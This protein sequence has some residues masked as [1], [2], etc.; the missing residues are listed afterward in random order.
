MISITYPYSNQLNQFSFCV[1]GSI[2]LEFR[3][4]DRE[5]VINFPFCAT[6]DAIVNKFHFY[7]NNVPYSI[8]F[9]IYVDDVTL[10]TVVDAWHILLTYFAQIGYGYET[11][12]DFDNMLLYRIDPV[13]LASLTESYADWLNLD[14]SHAIISSTILSWATNNGLMLFGDRANTD[15][16]ISMDASDSNLGLSG[17]H[18]FRY[19]CLGEL[20]PLI[21]AELD[22]MISTFESVINLKPSIETEIVPLST[23]HQIAESTVTTRLQIDE[24]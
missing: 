21:F 19:M 7:I 16:E 9:P 17:I 14:S 13:S 15:A 10:D 24:T 4:D 23:A 8:H 3:V 2:P 20:D 18:S 6:G 22:E 11:L 12:G 1:S 5:H